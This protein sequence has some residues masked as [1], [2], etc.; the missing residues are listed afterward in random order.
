MEK[1]KS[2]NRKLFYVFVG[3]GK[4]FDGVPWRKIL[5]DKKV[6]AAPVNG[7]LF[8]LF[9]VQGGVYQESVLS[10]LLFATVMGVLTEGMRDAS[11]MELF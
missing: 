5:N 3:L 6:A 2:K 11:L 10:I 4:T 9:L 1:Y 8:E 7:A